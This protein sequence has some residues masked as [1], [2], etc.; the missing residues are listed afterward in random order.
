MEIMT[1][2]RLEIRGD[3]T[4]ERLVLLIEPDIFLIILTCKSSIRW[5]IKP[6]FKLEG[7]DEGENE[8]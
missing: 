7:S 8:N 2:S 5:K 1:R 3:Q 4:K 6:S